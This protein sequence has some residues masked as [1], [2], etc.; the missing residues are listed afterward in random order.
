MCE[1]LTLDYQSVRRVHHWQH[2]TPSI[3]QIAQ[4]TSA[5]QKQVEL[6]RTRNL[7]LS[8]LRIW[9]EIG[10]GLLT[11]EWRIF[12]KPLAAQ[13]QH[14]ISSVVNAAA[15]PHNFDICNDTVP[16]SNTTNSWLMEDFCVNPMETTNPQR[17]PVHK[18]VCS[19]TLPTIS[20]IPAVVDGGLRK[21]SPEEIQSHQMVCP[22]IS[23]IQSDESDA[24]SI[25]EDNTDWAEQN[26][27]CE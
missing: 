2:C 8:Q 13:P 7:C 21:T 26:N 25:A 5:V 20:A 3:T 12:R 24:V 27:H 9:V 19:N 17:A 11:T 6:K 14:V 10:F 23:L 1:P 18:R 4:S 16:F 22:V 15:R